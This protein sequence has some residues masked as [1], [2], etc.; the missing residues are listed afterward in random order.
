MRTSRIGW[1]CFVFIVH[2]Q[3][4]KGDVLREVSDNVVGALISGFLR[5]KGA[6]SAPKFNTREHSVPRQK[7]ECQFLNSG[8]QKLFK[9]ASYFVATENKLVGQ[10]KIQDL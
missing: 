10:Q 8:I 6:W 9:V 3:R 7:C 2:R 4:E 1:L 5:I